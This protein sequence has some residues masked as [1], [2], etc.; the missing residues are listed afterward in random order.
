MSRSFYAA[1]EKDLQLYWNELESLA[2]KVN[3]GPPAPSKID[4]WVIK[5]IKRGLKK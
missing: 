3:F 4:L 5:N 1:E 2:N